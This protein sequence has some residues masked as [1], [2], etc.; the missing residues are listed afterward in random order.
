MPGFC[1][2]DLLKAAAGGAAGLVLRTRSLVAGPPPEA[3][4]TKRYFLFPHPDGSECPNVKKRGLLLVDIDEG[5]KD[6]RWT[7]ARQIETPLLAR[8]PH[9]NGPGV[10]GATVC[11]ATNRCYVSCSDGRSAFYLVCVD[12]GTG[13]VIYE[14]EVPGIGR[15]QITPD[16]STVF[17]P[18]DWFGGRSACAVDAETA[19]VKKTFQPRYQH[20]LAIGESGDYVYAPFR[21]NPDKPLTQQAGLHIIDAR[22]LRVVR[23]VYEEDPLRLIGTAPHIQVDAKERHVYSYCRMKCAMCLIECASGKQ[24]VVES[25]KLGDL[26]LD[27]PEPARKGERANVPPL[28]ERTPSYH[29]IAYFPDGKRAWVGVEGNCPDLVEFDLAA[30]LPKATR[31][32]Q[33]GSLRRAKGWAFISRKGDLVY[34]SNGR[35]FDTAG[36]KLLGEVRYDDDSPLY[37]SKLCEVHLR[38]QKVV[39]GSSSVACGYPA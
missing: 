16:G 29:G 22:T 39:F 12:L 3:A 35:I 26:W 5:L 7:V 34:T 14:K 20:H 6:G 21:K 31:V 11:A 27:A 23:E 8:V 38:G 32:I 17:L 9:G 18:V 10:R 25:V 13:R 30:G 19:E 2:R 4:S 36:G 28:V 37:S 1:R 15:P 24:Q 33:G